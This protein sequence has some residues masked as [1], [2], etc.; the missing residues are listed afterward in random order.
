MTKSQG[1]SS[2]MR[3]LCNGAPYLNPGSGK[4]SLFRIYN[5]FDA[6]GTVFVCLGFSICLFVNRLI[7]N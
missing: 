2:S 3:N 7:L 5:F 1:N 6:R 4:L